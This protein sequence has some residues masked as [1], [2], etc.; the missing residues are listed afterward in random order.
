[1][2]PYLNLLKQLILFF[3]NRKCYSTERMSLQISD[4]T[5]PSSRLAHSLLN[6]VYSRKTT[7]LVEYKIQDGCNNYLI[8]NSRSEFVICLY[9]PQALRIAPLMGPR[10]VPQNT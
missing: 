4:K 1:M 5:K 6:R 9:L 7:S 3:R 8:L 2:G 10:P